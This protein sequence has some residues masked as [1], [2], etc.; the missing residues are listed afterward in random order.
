M[1]VA[2]LVLIMIYRRRRL[3]MIRII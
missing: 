3:P 2:A 1:A